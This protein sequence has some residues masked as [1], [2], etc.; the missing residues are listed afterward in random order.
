MLLPKMC[1]YSEFFWSVFPRIWTE[2]EEILRIFPYS[3]RVRENSNRDQKNSEPE[4]FSRSVLLDLFNA[5]LHAQSLFTNIQHYRGA[6]RT[7]PNISD[8]AS[9]ENM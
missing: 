4:H 9:R 6:F 1:P 5:K 2:Y 7:P 3:V 8:R